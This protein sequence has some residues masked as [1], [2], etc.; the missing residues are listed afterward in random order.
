MELEI[1]P[2]DRSTRD[3]QFAMPTNQI[4]TAIRPLLN[5]LEKFIHRTPTSATP[6]NDNTP[7]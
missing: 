1:L 7:F 4:L 5:L 3:Y 6:T 2:L